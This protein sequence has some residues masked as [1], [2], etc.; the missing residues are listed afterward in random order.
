ML[1]SRWIVVIAVGVCLFAWILVN[2]FVYQMARIE[3]MAMAPTLVSQDRVVVNKWLYL[4]SS[5][6]RGDIVMFRYPP[7]PELSFIK[8]IVARG[9]DTLRIEDGRV[10]VN[11][12]VVRD[13]AYVSKTFRS[14]EDVPEHA[15]TA[16]HYYVLGDNRT[17]SADSR[18]WGEVPEANIDGRVSARWWPTPGLI[19]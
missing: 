8:R 18:I 3:G 4:M 17:N 15:I 6:Q 10:Y 12:E 11:G 2:A 1:R 16:G 5:P 14:H 13:D 19:R 7:N 9:G